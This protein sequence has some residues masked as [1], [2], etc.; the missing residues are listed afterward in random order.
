MKKFELGRMVQTRGVA[1]KAR[2]DVLFFFFVQKSLNQYVR[3]DWGEMSEEDKKNNDMA[4]IRN[5]DR[6]FASYKDAYRE[7]WHIWII[8]EM[9]RS[10]TTILFP[11]EY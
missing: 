10:C 7:D 3:C 4:V 5:G 8:T 2:D 11:D 9:D 6:I 1:Q